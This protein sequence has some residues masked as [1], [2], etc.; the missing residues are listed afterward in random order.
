MRFPEFAEITK[1][2]EKVLL[3][4]GNTPMIRG[5]ENETHL[6]SL[7]VTSNSVPTYLCVGVG[8]GSQEVNVPCVLNL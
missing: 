1:L 8:G 3:H 6:I 2:S 5:A 4:L 7:V